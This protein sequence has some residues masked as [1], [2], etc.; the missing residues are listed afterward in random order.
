VKSPR[1]PVL[2]LSHCSDRK[3]CGD[4]RYQGRARATSGGSSENRD[5]YLDIDLLGLDTSEGE[6]S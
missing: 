3:Y 4:R 6:V 1:I 5:A 2:T